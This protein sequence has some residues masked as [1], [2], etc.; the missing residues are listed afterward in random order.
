MRLQR[1]NGNSVTTVNTWTQ[2]VNS[3]SLAMSESATVTSNG[4]YR[5]VVDATV[6]RNGVAESISITGQVNTKKTE[7]AYISPRKE[8]NY[9]NS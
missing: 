8:I 9:E 4:T 1:V 2:S 7:W 6:T 3:S 5:L